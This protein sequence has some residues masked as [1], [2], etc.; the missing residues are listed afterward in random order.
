MGLVFRPYRSN[1]GGRVGDKK[2]ER[3]IFLLIIIVRIIWK[4]RYFEFMELRIRGIMKSLNIN[5]HF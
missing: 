2:V 3:E 4:K 5:E 1:E